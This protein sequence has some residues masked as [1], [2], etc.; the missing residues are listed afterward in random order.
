MAKLCTLN[1]NVCLLPILNKTHEFP[2]VVSRVI[3]PTATLRMPPLRLPSSS[4]ASPAYATVAFGSELDPKVRGRQRA[5]ANVGKSGCERTFGRATGNDQVAPR[6]AVR[7]AIL[8]TEFPTA[9]RAVTRMDT[10]ITL[11]PAAFGIAALGHGPAYQGAR[12]LSGIAGD[13][14][15]RFR[16][17]PRNHALS[18][19]KK[20]WIASALGSVAAPRFSQDAPSRCCP[21]PPRGRSANDERK[22]PDRKL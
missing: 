17:S 21:S 1:P 13:S 22:H 12:H 4:S 18:T 9:S 10:A 3:A 11:L 5:I 16:S 19:V 8:L 20:G 7:A 6:A 2:G 15:N 14:M